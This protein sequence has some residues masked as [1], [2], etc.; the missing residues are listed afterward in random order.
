MCEMKV[1]LTSGNGDRNNRLWTDNEEVNE[2]EN[3]AV[4]REDKVMARIVDSPFLADIK[5]SWL[6]LQGWTSDMPKME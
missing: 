3:L 6:L 2:K 1:Q 5:L 4:G